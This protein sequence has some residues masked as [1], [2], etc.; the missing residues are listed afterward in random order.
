MSTA[1][2]Q[3]RAADPQASVW[4][5]ANAGSG[6][7][8][9]L[10]K[11]VVRLLL[12]GNDPAKILCLTFT[13]AAAANMQD[14]V[15]TKELGRW[16]S[17]SDEEL[18]AAITETTGERPTP[19]ELRRARRLF[20]KAVETPGGLKIQTIHGFCER[21]LHLFPF[22]AGVPARF[23]VM[24]DR[25]TLAA[26]EAAIN[27]TFAAALAEPEQPLGR[28]LRIATDAAGEE[29]FRDALRAFMEARR[30]IET[31]PM[32]RKFAVSPLRAKLG[33]PLG[34]TVEAVRRRI[35]AEGL[36]R[37]DWRS[38]CTWLKSSLKDRDREI[39]D[40]MEN[41]FRQD[42]NHVLEH[43]VRCF[44]SA[45]GKP[46][47]DKGWFIS[48]ELRKQEAAHIETLLA[49]RERIVELMKQLGCVE[50][51]ER[52]EAI[53]LLADEVNARYRAEKRRLSRLDFPDLIGKVVKLLREDAARWVLY[54]LDQGLDHVLVD[55]AQ[56]TSPEQ[57]RIVK[58]L[59]D[60]FFA[61]HGARGDRI[62]TIFAVGDEKQSIFGFQGAR[63]EEFDRSFRHFGQRIA[64]YNAEAPEP[65]AF[66]KVPLQISYRT[67]D[68][69]L[70][71]VDQIFSL[72]Q[73]HRGLSSEN[74][75]TVHKSNRQNEPASSSSGRPSS[76]RRRRSAIHSP[77]SI[78]RPSMR[79]P[80]GS[81]RRSRGVSGTGRR[82][83]PVS[84]ATAAASF[85]ATCWC[86]CAAAGR[87]SIA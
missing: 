23:Q 86:W 73:N 82:L 83:G 1:S 72:E 59:A 12:A 55:E 6:K 15:F 41:G 27:A 60:D 67:V 62:R 47:S 2:P 13:K 43:Y 33:V 40:F 52:S 85:R 48:A 16:V 69:I 24:D 84:N 38:I 74:E 79:P 29:T 28:A 34:E 80:S 36:Y 58:A 32:E 49:E 25:E 75:K 45:E 5:S 21:L 14:R 22:E 63:P 35:V 78:R 76:P 57:W 65:H 44:L 39:A 42:G 87:C 20:A 46:R 61:G 64:A 3:H 71:C 70:T 9:V 37:G 56:D 7:T 54:K 81:P 19:G 18:S 66:S 10:A 50:A 11:R 4:V 8:T 26:R 17:L 31:P 30:P 53:T 68:D 77:R 51:C